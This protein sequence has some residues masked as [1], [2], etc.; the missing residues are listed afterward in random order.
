M[1]KL[2][3]GIFCIAANIS[4]W[5][6]GW[7]TRAWM[8]ST[9]WIAICSVERRSVAISLIV[10]SIIPSSVI[11]CRSNVDYNRFCQVCL[12]QRNADLRS[13]SQN[14]QPGKRQ[15]IISHIHLHCIPFAKV[16]LKQGQ[17]QWIL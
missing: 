7:P 2:L 6:T 8:R 17:S 13:L 9:N 16:A 11:G 3:G 15:L 10:A 14:A 5:D 4:A 1:D 12:W